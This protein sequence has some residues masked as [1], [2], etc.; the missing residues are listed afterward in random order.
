M[1]P[2]LVWAFLLLPAALSL[3]VAVWPSLSHAA[4]AVFC[5]TCDQRELCWWPA[6]PGLSLDESFVTPGCSEHEVPGEPALSSFQAGS[7]PLELLFSFSLPSIFFHLIHL[8]LRA[9][10]S[11]PPIA[12]APSV[13]S[14]WQCSAEPALLGGLVHRKPVPHCVHPTEASPQS[15]L[16]SS[17][18]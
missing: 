2:L 5:P 11:R 6:G 18:S 17:T 12:P 9:F 1:Q 3:Q 7:G 10:S 16:D 13:G 14:C 4:P 15:G 8:F